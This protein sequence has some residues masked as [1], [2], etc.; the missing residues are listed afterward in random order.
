[1]TS[2]PPTQA[3]LLAAL[4]LAGLDLAQPDLEAA[5]AVSAALRD[6][7]A[8][9]RSLRTPVTPPALVLEVLP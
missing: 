6:L 9:A 8:A 3:Q 2:P 4:E 1:V 5:A 7:F